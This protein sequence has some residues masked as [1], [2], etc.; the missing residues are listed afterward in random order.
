MT[1]LW[2]N[3]IKQKRALTNRL[4]CFEIVSKRNVTI[5][6]WKITRSKFKIFRSSLRDKEINFEQKLKKL[7]FPKKKKNWKCK[8]RRGTR[9]TRL[10]FGCFC[11]F[12]RMS[13]FVMSV[14]LIRMKKTFATIFT[15]ERKMKN[16]SSEF[17]PKKS[18]S[19]YRNGNL[20]EC[21]T[22]LWSRKCS[23][24]TKVFT[25]MSHLS[26]RSLGACFAAC[27]F[28]LSFLQG[29]F[30]MKRKLAKSFLFNKNKSRSTLDI[31]LGWKG[32]SKYCETD[33]SESFVPR[34]SLLTSLLFAFERFRIGM[35]ADVVSI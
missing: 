29:D 9:R 25:Q 19:F 12:L 5:W 14:K 11:V 18:F 21:R 16:W 30:S 4:N 32:K 6:M 20:W 1:E 26:I 35:F 7:K 22:I 8:K 13:L 2:G 23:G 17:S 34:K 3:K 33:F 15:A 27:C 28:N 24:L 31:W 10:F